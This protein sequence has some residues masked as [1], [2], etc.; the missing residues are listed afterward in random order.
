MLF[1]DLKKK[2]IP[3]LLLR[4]SPGLASLQ[5]SPV[6]PVF[7]D[8]Y[9]ASGQ[10]RLPY[11]ELIEPFEIF[12]QG[13]KNRSRMDTYSGESSLFFLLGDFVSEMK[14][15]CINLRTGTIY[16]DSVYLHPV[17]I[18]TRIL[19]SRLTQAPHVHTQCAIFK[20]LK[21]HFSWKKKKKKIDRFWPHT[22]ELAKLVKH[23]PV[24]PK[25]VG[26]NPTQ[27]ED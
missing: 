19:A 16:L 24:Q 7:K 13:P 11:A 8:H 18:C 3:S 4:D 5:A 14:R 1:N 12:F 2:F 27:A 21:Q 25:F 6:K 20:A 23:L 17:H 26:L 15:C 10:I 22:G 9:H